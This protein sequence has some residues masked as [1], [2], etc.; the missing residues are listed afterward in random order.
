MQKH[1]VYYDYTKISYEGKI[2]KKNSVR[3]SDAALP[4]E[5]VSKFYFDLKMP[6]MVFK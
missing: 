3:Y 6:K 5:F 4:R 2:Q 1:L